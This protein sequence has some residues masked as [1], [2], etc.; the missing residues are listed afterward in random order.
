SVMVIALRNPVVLARQVATLDNI[1][2]GRV[3]FGIGA[4]G[5]PEEFE[6]IGVPWERRG[7]RTDEYLKVMKSLWTEEQPSFKG[8]FVSFPELFCNPKPAEEGGPPLFVGGHSNAAYRRVGRYA[9]A[10]AASSA[11]SDDVKAGMAKIRVEA[12]LVGRDS[13][14]ISVLC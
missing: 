5:I 1:S 2:N 9:D 8:E 13:S 11:D 3:N 7:A 14:E 10:W 12:E 6:C 4:G